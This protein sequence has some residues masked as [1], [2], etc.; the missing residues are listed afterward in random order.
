MTEIS[1]EELERRMS[2]KLFGSVAAR[3]PVVAITRRRSADQRP[4]ETR[5][6]F[7]ERKKREAALNV[8]DDN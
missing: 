3:F 5:R 1:D 8:P 6:Q 4:G 7:I 2:A